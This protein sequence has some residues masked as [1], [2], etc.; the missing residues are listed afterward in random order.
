[1]IVCFHMFE[2]DSSHQFWGVGGGVNVRESVVVDSTHLQTVLAECVDCC[3]KE[4][5]FI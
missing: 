5:H 4:L 1:M 2:Q 3:L